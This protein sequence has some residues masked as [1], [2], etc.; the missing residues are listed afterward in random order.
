MSDT[1]IPRPEL[2]IFDCDGVLVDS[3]PISNTVLAR[4]LTEAGLPT[5]LEDALAAYKGRILADVL[6]IAEQRLGRELPVRFVEH[7]EAERE[8][9]FRRSLRAVDGASDVV[10]RI[11]AAGIP[12][13]VATQGKPE[14]TE[15]TLGLTGLRDLFAPGTLFSAYAVA[16]GKPFPD[17]FLHA[18]EQMGARPE[19]TTVVEDTEIGVR[20]AVAAGMRALGLAAAGD[21]DELWAAGAEPIASLREVP[22]RLG[23]TA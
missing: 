14:K 10:K 19:R 17:L 21:P 23:L 22:A 15:L 20:A 11:A 4:V 6:A 9:E 13:C 12:V 5:T 2:V 7:Y 8:L 16:R 1:D 18:A 3:E